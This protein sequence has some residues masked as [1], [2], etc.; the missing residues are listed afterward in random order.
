MQLRH[1]ARHPSILEPNVWRCLTRLGEAGLWG[2]RRIGVFRQGYTFLRRAESRIRIV[3]NLSRDDL[4]ENDE[5]ARKLALRMGYEGPNAGQ[6]LRA[7]SV[8]QMTRIREEFLAVLGD[9]RSRP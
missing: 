7:D 3:Q 8:E 5:D 4:P 1:A 6:L 2:V 9:E